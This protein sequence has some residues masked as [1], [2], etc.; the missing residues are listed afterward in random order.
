MGM[1]QAQGLSSG[2][3]T[4]GTSSV[5]SSAT[6][7]ATPDNAKRQIQGDQWT[8]SRDP[9]LGIS[10]QVLFWPIVLAHIK[11][12][13]TTASKVDLQCI[14][15]FGSPWLLAAKSRGYFSRFSL[16]MDLRSSRLRSGATVFPEL[17]IRRVDELCIAYFE[18]FNSLFPL[19]EMHSFLDGIIARLAQEGYKGGDPEAV[20]G[21]L[22]FALGELAID[23]GAAA[24]HRSDPCNSCGCERTSRP[25]SGYFNEACRRMKAINSRDYLEVVQIALLQATYFGAVSRN[26]D[27]FAAIST[28]SSAC[29]SLLKA[30]S[31]DWSSLRGNLIKR[32]YWLCVLH[33]RLFF[34]EF[35]VPLTG[36]DNWE[37]EVPL[38]HLGHCFQAF[39]SL[40]LPSANVT[41]GR[42]DFLTCYFSAMIA[43][44]R[45]IGRINDLIYGYESAC[46]DA[47]PLLS[48]AEESANA[49]E[50]ARHIEEY[51]G[52]PHHIMEEFMT[53]QLDQ[54]RDTLPGVLQ[55]KDSTQQDFAN[56]GLREQHPYLRFFGHV[57]HTECQEAPHELDLVQAHLRVRFYNARY[58]LN[59]P[60]IY[61]ALHKPQLMTDNDKE[62]CKISVESACLWPLSLKPPKDKRHI[63]PHLF[64]WTQSFASLTLVIRACCDLGTFEELGG[65]TGKMR[66]NAEHSSAVMIEWLE[67]VRREDYI[68]DWALTNLGP[69]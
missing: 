45:L 59:R 46:E 65:E 12:A 67:D 55:W 52:P 27:S 51:E 20:L 13:G 66:A 54:W 35:R 37:D 8:Q 42:Q 17:T 5:S 36:I 4:L 33:E 9:L 49:K 29:I 34:I 25:G 39:D 19:L 24:S 32:A 69:L 60:F 6:G 40:S 15:R 11:D 1:D 44:S 48:F 10:H 31:V 63:L 28:A 68:A 61:K 14:L 43:L 16:D 50:N 23:G 41:L 57:L 53:R 2:S 7:P 58:L 56:V 30:Q 21:L 18:T 38:P 26:S 47:E 62:Q 3:R 22:V 64:A